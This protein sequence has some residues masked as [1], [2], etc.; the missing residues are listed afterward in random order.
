[1]ARVKI[2]LSL[3]AVLFLIGAGATWFYHSGVL[4]LQN[5]PEKVLQRK[6]DAALMDD[7]CERIDT[8][9]KRFKEE[10]RTYRRTS[11]RTTESESI[12]SLRYL[13]AD[14]P[15]DFPIRYKGTHKYGK[16]EKAAREWVNIPSAGTQ[17]LSSELQQLGLAP[18]DQTSSVANVAGSDRIAPGR[19]ALV[20]GNSQ[21]LNRP[22]TN[23]E[24]DA[25]DVAG[26]LKSA[27]FEIIAVHDGTRRDM[28]DAISAFSER[29]KSNDVGFV[30]YSGHGVEHMGR[31]YLIPVNAQLN[32]EDE[33]PRQTID[34]T[35][36][37]DRITRVEH[38]VTILVIDACRSSFIPSGNRSSTQGLRKMDGT[39]GA[40]VGFSTAPGTVAEDGSGRNSPYTRNLLKAMDVPGRKIEDVF[41]EAAR[42]VEIET[43]GR[44]IPWYTS[45]LLVDF[46]LK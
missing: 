31:N 5:T 24:H 11:L 21:Y 19:L 40:I 38:K 36:L 41:K 37:L 45:S 3:F 20:I 23:P 44:Q 22:L 33:I 39:S 13:L 15:K 17:P 29:L 26:F 7:L 27:G 6:I 2:E 4:E 10:P 30:Y 46:S 43:G 32:T 28:E 42:A 18:P 35:A 8:D 12:E 1:M 25:A 16:C 14:V 34:A 9:I